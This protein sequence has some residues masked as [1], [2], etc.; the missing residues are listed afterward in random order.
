MT[1]KLKII[2]GLV[3]VVCAF[4]CAMTVFYFINQQT[5]DNLK[6]NSALQVQLANLIAEKSESV[7]SDSDRRRVKRDRIDLEDLLDRTEK[8]YGEQELKRKDGV[9]WIDRVSQ[10]CMVT[11]GAANGLVVGS[12][13]AAYEEVAGTAGTTPTNQKVCDVVVEQTYDIVSYVRLVERNLTDLSRD[14][15]RVSVKDTR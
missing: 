8:V 15:Y 7:L 12:Y 2:I 11:L 14:Y 3:L 1:N 13:L 6:E 9:L 10:R 5:T 4:L